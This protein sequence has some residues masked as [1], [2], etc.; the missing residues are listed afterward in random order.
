MTRTR[1]AALLAAGFSL[2]AAAPLAAPLTAQEPT[3]ITA[4]VAPAPGPYAPGVDVLHYEVE[5]AIEA[6]S[7]RIEAAVEITVA[8]EAHQAVLPLDLTGLEITE[9]TVDGRT[10]P[11][12]HEEGVVR[13]PMRS[14]GPGDV[15]RVHVAYRGTPDDGL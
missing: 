1:F 11:Y 10:V 3:P 13:V 4:G 12:L 8:L 7:D 2:A 15:V 9:L 14:A 5:I 6:G